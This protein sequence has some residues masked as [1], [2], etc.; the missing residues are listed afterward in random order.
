MTDRIAA[1]DTQ[2]RA[3]SDAQLQAKTKTFQER[4]QAG[5]SLTDIMIDAYAT[6]IEA[7]RR[8]LGLTPY[9]EQ[10][11]G[12]VALQFNNVAEMKTGEGKTL[13]AT[14][15]MYLNGLTGPGNFLIT[16]NEYLAN[17]DA[18]N[19]GRVYSWLG[20]SVSAGVAQP[21]EDDDDRDL[22][23]IYSS[24]IVYTTNSALGFDYL[25]DNLAASPAKKYI[26]PFHFALLDEVDAI[27]LIKSP[28]RGEFEVK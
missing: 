12:G 2:Y 4:L 18:A 25:L 11:L 28:G 6:V 24:N 14:M 20:L 10:I 8:V 26:Q 21:G 19:I 9:R 23:A 16:A 5:A 3:L 7:D 27:L 22:Q 17:R 13:T 1:L 15:P